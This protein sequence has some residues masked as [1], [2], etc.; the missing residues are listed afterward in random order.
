MLKKSWLLLLSYWILSGAA[1]G[2]QQEVI[3]ILVS[4][5]QRIE[6]EAIRVNL[7][8]KIGEPFSSSQIRDDI[9]NIYKS[10][11]FSDVQVDLEEK[12]EGVIVTFIVTELPLVRAV[13]IS[14]NK[15]L[16]EKDLRELVEIKPRSV[17]DRKS[18]QESCR[19]IKSMYADKGFYLAEVDYSL[20][21]SE[22]GEVTVELK[23]KENQEV[24]VKR[25]NFIGNK[26]FSAEELRSIMDTK[27]SSYLSWFT[28]RG[29][30]KEETLES[31]ITKVTGH[32]YNNGYIQFKISPPLISL[33]PDKKWIYIAFK[34]E[35]GEQFYVGRIELEGDLIFGEEKILRGLRTKEGDVF[36]RARI[37]EDI[38]V[39]TDRYANLGYASAN[40]SPMT[41]IDEQKKR[42]DLTFEIEKGKLVYFDRIKIVGNTKTRDKVIRRELRVKEGQLF[43]GSGLRRSRQRVY[44][45]GFF[46]EVNMSTEPSEKENMLDA[47]VEVKEGHTG[48][49]SAGFGYSSVDRFVGMIQ[50]SLGNFFGLG[51]RVSLTAEFGKTRQNYNFSFYEPYFLDS[52][53]S[54]GLD[55]FKSERTYTDFT[56][57][58]DGGSIRWGYRV[59]EYT[60]VFL[61][62]RYEDI[63]IS[64]IPKPQEGITSSLTGSLTRD[65]RDHP[66]D[67]SRGSVNSFSVEYAGGFLQGNYD[68]TKFSLSSRWYFPVVWGTV[69]MFHG[70]SGYG[71]ADRELPFSERYFLGGINSVRGYQYWSLGP[72]D[73]ILLSEGLPTSSTQSVA[74]GGNKMVVMNLEFLFPIIKEAGLKG[75]LFLDGGNAYRE[76]ESFFE[77]PLRA[78]WGFGFR[79]FTPIAPFR[80]EW[81]FPFKKPGEDIESSIFEFSIGTFF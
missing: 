7:K 67:P 39:L 73:N 51:Q 10:G 62:Y 66:F 19:K 30:F 22:R 11:W 48:T 74:V 41:R 47:K 28:S 23:I 13:K 80:F 70:R 8:T 2:V 50:T 69:L 24:Q 12:P 36:S 38:F 3:D 44:A 42:V 72:R 78:S 52:S 31:D 49:L 79:W 71:L 75:L 43:S 20:K 17:L 59:A 21:P 68:F 40:I 35:E 18:L 56:R 60:R 9:K 76:S 15:K 25:I 54:F 57:S 46:E 45:T 64:D 29:V 4:G 55:L 27:Q 34:L 32:Y 37:S 65:S 81:G 61:S 53:W 63:E 77:S 16:D 5:N 26:A 6:E 14:G 1:M 33:S 58:S